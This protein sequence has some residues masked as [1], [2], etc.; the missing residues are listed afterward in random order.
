MIRNQPKNATLPSIKHDM[1]KRIIGGKYM[2][3][4]AHTP[5]QKSI[6]NGNLVK[7]YKHGATSK[8]LTMKK[9]KYFKSGALGQQGSHTG[10]EVRKE[11][12]GWENSQN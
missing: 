6:S 11:A 12:A 4:P 5:R 3:A 10:K 2:T 8:N 1:A 7:G 9:D